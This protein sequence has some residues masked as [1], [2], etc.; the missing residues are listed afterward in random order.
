MK[1][2]DKKRK[3]T[4][5]EIDLSNVIGGSLNILG[6]KVD[7]GQLFSLNESAGAVKQKLEELRE[8]LQKAGGKPVSIGGHIR[9]SGVLGQRDFSIVGRES[10]KAYKKETPVEEKP[11]VREPFVDLFY[12]EDKKDNREYVKIVAELPGLEEKDIKVE[13]QAKTLILS[14]DTLRRK[15]HKKIKLD[16]LVKDAVHRLSYHNGVVELELDK[17]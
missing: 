8:Q 5:D 2:G 1:A 7:L 16:Y 14:A 3:D 9:T 17:Q 6:M 10:V 11:E 12:E 13:V 4:E 15:Y